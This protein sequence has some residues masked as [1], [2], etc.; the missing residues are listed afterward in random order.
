MNYISLL[1]TGM[2]ELRIF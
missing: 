1:R 2:G